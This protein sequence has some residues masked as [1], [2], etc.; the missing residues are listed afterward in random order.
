M[1]TQEDVDALDRELSA[2]ENANRTIL[3]LTLTGVLSTS[4][5]ARLETILSRHEDRFGALE[6][7][8]R[9]T[10]LKVLPDENDFA[11]IPADGYLKKTVDEL[12]GRAEDAVAFE[13][14]ML[15]HQIMSEEK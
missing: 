4:Q 3:K 15:L 5:K 12:S 9:H 7:W 10:N 13:A 1:T 6:Y 11:D 14:L 2:V 8:Q